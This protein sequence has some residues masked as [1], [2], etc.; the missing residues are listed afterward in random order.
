MKKIIIIGI[1]LVLIISGLTGVSAIKL[2]ESNNTFYVS[3]TGSNIFGDGSLKKPWL[4]IQYAIDNN[5]VTNGDTIHVFSGTYKENIIV[6]KSIIVEGDDKNTTVISGDRGDWVVE[7]KTNH[8]SIKGFTIT[9]GD[10]GIHFHKHTNNNF[11][12]DNNIMDQY[13]YGMQIHESSDNTISCNIIKNCITG[14]GISIY[15]SPSNTISGNIIEN[16]NVEGIY[17]DES[18]GTTIINNLIKN[19]DVGIACFTCSSNTIS[20]NTISSNLLVGLL[21]DFSSNYNTIFGNNIKNCQDGQGIDISSSSYNTL[22]GNII[23]NAYYGIQLT[24]GE[25]NIYDNS[26]ENIIFDNTIEN[27]NIGIDFWWAGS[28]GNNNIHNNTIKNN[29]YGITSYQSHNN[30]IIDNLIENKGE[31]GIDLWSSNF[32]TISGNTIS[33]YKYGINIHG[34]TGYTREDLKGNNTFF[35]NRYNIVIDGKKTREV[36]GLCLIHGRFLSLYTD[37]LQKILHKTNYVKD[38]FLS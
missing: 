15:H 29:R 1:I 13:Y 17:L 9:G 20:G 16:N 22:Q 23:S 19:H 27:N 14:E 7:I 21:L 34:C 30:I 38:L 6:D 25:G 37:V 10:H 32:Y 8:V 5:K 33:K 36:K 35:R 26:K 12:F 11:I 2:E 28:A 18:P 3:K 24:C 4:T 31:I